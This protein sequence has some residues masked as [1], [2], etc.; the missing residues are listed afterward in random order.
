MV[1]FLRGGQDGLNLV[2]PV[3]GNDRAAYQALRAQPA[4]PRR[5]AL[6]LPLGTHGGGQRLVARHPPR[7]GAAA[8]ALPGRQAG[9][10]VVGCGMAANE[11]SHFDSMDWMELGTPGRQST[12]TGWLTRHLQSAS[13][14]PAD[15]LMPSLSVGGMQAMSLLG[16]YETINLSSPYD[17]ALYTGPWAGADRPAPGAA[18]S[19]RRGHHL[20]AP[21]E[22]EGA[23][24]GRHR[25]ALR[26]RRLRP[27]GRRRLSGHLVRR[28]PADH[29]A[30]DQARPRPAHRDARPRRVG[31]PRE[32]GRDLYASLADELAQR[33]AAP[34]GRTSTAR[35]R[36]LHAAADRRGDE[37]VRPPRLRERRPRHRPRPRQQH[38]RALG[39]RDRRP[40]RHLA[41]AGAGAARQTATSRSPPTSGGCSP[42][43]SSAVWATPAST[44]SFPATAAI[45]HSA[46]CRAPWRPLR[47]RRRRTF[48]SGTASRG[49]TA[50][51][52]ASRRPERQ[53]LPSGRTSP[54]GGRLSPPASSRSMT[55]A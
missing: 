32:P 30:D 45:S 44:S 26:E 21:D 49:A 25:R 53:G 42:R 29:R 48:S 22:P 55:S 24:R 51:P 8:R 37:R 4:D 50:P 39:Q 38:V 34:S 14:L 2:V 3:A 20:A 18:Q 40:A 5:A 35:R 17:F 54:T 33:P 36:Q 11:R 31:P 47:R 27:V 16:S 46:W 12:A 43:S 28:Q 9:S 15:I 41:R 13:N 19:G 10:S 6:A 23:R 1:L 7:G 52:G